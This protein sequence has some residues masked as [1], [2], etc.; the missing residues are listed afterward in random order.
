MTTG[1]VS[2]FV[3][4][5]YRPAVP[6]DVNRT[7][8]RHFASGIGEH[9][10]ACHDVD[11]ARALGYPDLVA[12]PTFGIVA[13]LPAAEALVRELGL[14]FSRVVHGEQRFVLRRP[15]IAGDSL[16]VVVTV[17]RVRAVAGS[18]ILTTRADIADADGAPIGTATTTLIVRG[19]A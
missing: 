15:I 3:G 18:Q 5:S 8:I 9:H 14:D 10:P 19:E 11:A 1:T 12:P 6:F 16:D 4:R 13:T 7:I 17:E 2:D